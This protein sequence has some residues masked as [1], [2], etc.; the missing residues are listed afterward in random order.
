MSHALVA[1]LG[2][3]ATTN[4]SHWLPFLATLCASVPLLMPLLLSVHV[5]TGLQQEQ[6]AAIMRAWHATAELKV[7]AIKPYLKELLELLMEEEGQKILVFGH[8]KWVVVQ[9]TGQPT[10]YTGV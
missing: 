4:S 6:Q 10:E 7:A 9:G 1:T 5:C 8:H 3:T 2:T